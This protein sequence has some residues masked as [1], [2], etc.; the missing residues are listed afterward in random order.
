[1]SLRTRER[2]GRSLRRPLVTLCTLALLGLVAGGTVFSTAKFNFKTANPGNAL[3]AATFSF[4]NSKDGQVI[5][6]AVNLRP[7]QTQATTL[8]ITAAGT[9]NG[10]YTLVR[11]SLTNV[12]ASPAVSG[13][14]NLRVQDL[15]AGTTP[16]DGTFTAL[17]S[18]SLGTIPVG[19]PH[20]LQFTV[21]FPTATATA[22][23]QGSSCTMALTIVGV[24]Q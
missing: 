6:N 16:Y 2:H 21:S 14:L 8:V 7:G 11:S 24:A 18:V 3:G 1:M 23:Y 20:T 9:R 13:V 12:P 15:T 22:A 19:T 10:L 17:A 4:T 5:I